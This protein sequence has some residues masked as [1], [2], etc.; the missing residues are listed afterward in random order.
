MRRFARFACID[1]SGAKGPRQKGIAVAVCQRGNAA[2]ALVPHPGGWSRE[3][4][5]A[6]LVAHADEATDILIGIDFSTSLPFADHDAFFPGWSD[7]P[8]TGRE[9]W[10]FVDRHC[11]TDPHLAATSFVD[12]EEASAHFRRSDG[13]QGPHFGERNGRLRITERRCRDQGQ[14]P[15]QSCFNLVGAAQVGKSSLTGMRMLHRLDGR[16]PIW[17]FD[18]PPARGPL[19]VEVYTTIASRAARVSRGSKMRDHAAL[20]DALAELG[21]TD[22]P[23]LDRYDDHATDAILTAAW[24][25]RA[26][27]E[28]PLWMPPGLTPELAATEGWT[29]G[30]R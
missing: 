15:A 10:E 28:S 22:A 5:L 18:A 24:L 26:A 25:R 4:V 27:G 11:A 12:H 23:A 3:G 30:V 21:V 19:I 1:W 29:F 20:R 6:W 13:R 2:P 9:L 17:P 14:G 7:V 16:V 8:E